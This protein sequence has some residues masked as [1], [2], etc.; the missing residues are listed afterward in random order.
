MTDFLIT[1]IQKYDSRIT[2]IKA[3]PYNEDKATRKLNFGEEQGFTMRE[4]YDAISSKE[5]QFN[6][7]NISNGEPS[8]GDRIV[9]IPDTAATLMSVNHY[10]YPTPALERFM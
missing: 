3:R 7:L 1:S 8:V 4:V 2:Q 6:I 5:H 9:T 10:G